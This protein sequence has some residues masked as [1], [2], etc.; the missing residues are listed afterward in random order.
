MVIAP[1]PCK[2]CGMGY[3]E[4]ALLLVVLCKLPELEFE[5]F[6][7]IHSLL[8][9]QGIHGINRGT[10]AFLAGKFLHGFL[11]TDEFFALRSRVFGSLDR[12]NRHKIPLLFLFYAGASTS[13]SAVENLQSSCGC[14]RSLLTRFDWSRLTLRRMPWPDPACLSLLF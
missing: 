8:H 4:Y 13:P 5:F 7:G 6:R 3:Q 2:R 12:R 11:E 14:T 10:K 9:Q 1:S